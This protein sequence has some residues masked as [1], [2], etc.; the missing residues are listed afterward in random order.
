MTRGKPISDMSLRRYRQPPG[1][2]GIFE[3]WRASPLP[4]YTLGRRSGLSYNGEYY[5]GTYTSL[6]GRQQLIL[7]R[8]SF[9]LSV[10]TPFARGVQGPPRAPLAAAPRPKVKNPEQV[11]DGCQ[12]LSDDE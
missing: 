9:V 5:L 4:C 8:K 10:V 11:H 3:T 6:F 12:Y 1:W 7:R 2:N